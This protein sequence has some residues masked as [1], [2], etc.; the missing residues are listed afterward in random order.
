MRRSPFLFMFGP[1]FRTSK[2][3]PTSSHIRR[4]PRFL[5]LVLLP[6]SILVG[7][8]PEAPREKEVLQ[9]Y[10]SGEL[11]R[12][13]IE[14]DGKK[15]GEMTEYFKDGKVQMVRQFVNDV[16][17]GKTTVYYPSGAVREVQYYTDGKLEG[18]DTMF[19]EDGKPEFVR[20]F[21]TGKLDGDVRKFGRDGAVIFEA[22]YRL[23][24]LVEANGKAIVRD[25]LGNI[26]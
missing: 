13:H 7:C 8:K 19:Y 18:G 5:L 24:T 25:S 4:I 6:G 2:P 23:D 15:E 21:V 17:T 3:M 20:T 12:R 26:R 11:Q 9:H 22:K 16:Q 14:I 1:E 10:P